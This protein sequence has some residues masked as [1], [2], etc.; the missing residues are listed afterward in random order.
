M[1]DATVIY[2]H[3]HTHTVIYREEHAYTD[4]NWEDIYQNVK[5]SFI[6]KM[7]LLVI[8]T[9]F[10]ILFGFRIHHF[11]NLRNLLTESLFFLLRH[12]K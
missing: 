9:Y 2:T 11:H 7:V 5:C 6:L 8:F 3:T 1:Y 4:K 12:W 10:L